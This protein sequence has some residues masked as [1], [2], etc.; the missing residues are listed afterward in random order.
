MVWWQWVLVY[1]MGY[2]VTM[3]M[4]GLVVPNP[5]EDYDK[6]KNYSYEQSSAHNDWMWANILF[7]LGWP[8]YGPALIAWWC[9]RSLRGD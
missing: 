4:R 5:I 2:M 3:F 8:I 7:P 6:T 1:I 9:G